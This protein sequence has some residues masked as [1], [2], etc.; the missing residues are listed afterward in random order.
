MINVKARSPW[1]GKGGQILA[2]NFS[3]NNVVKLEVVEA[4][5]HAVDVTPTVQEVE[6]AFF[7]ILMAVTDGAIGYGG[8]GCP[9]FVWGAL[10]H[11]GSPSG[12]RWFSWVSGIF[13]CG[14]Q[15][16]CEFAQN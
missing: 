15:F 12:F 14:H 5:P 4:N 13:S 7:I 1:S 2:S 6:D 9:D 8:E 11:S 10:G 16:S 3:Q